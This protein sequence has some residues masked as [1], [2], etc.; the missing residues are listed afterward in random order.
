MPETTKLQEDFKELIEK[1]LPQ[2]V[3]A[4]LVTELNRLKKLEGEL[5]T[6]TA[7][8]KSSRASAD[9]Y[10]KTISTLTDKLLNI[11][12]RE[13]KVIENEQILAKEKVALEIL[14]NTYELTIKHCEKMESTML[15]MFRIPFSN[16]ILRESVLQDQVLR[17][18]ALVRSTD[19]NS[20]TGTYPQHQLHSEELAPAKKE[21]TV[22]EV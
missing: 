13:Q 3:G 8:L 9:E 6:A 1:H 16:R 2:Q 21:T 10:R 5:E 17:K 20:Q 19:Y 11:T 12:L 7:D 14:R 15:E 18:D 22:E 4:T